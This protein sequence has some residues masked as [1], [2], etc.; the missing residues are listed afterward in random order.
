MV[1]DPK[2]SLLLRADGTY[3][4]YDNGT[5]GRYRYDAATG[6][7]T[8]LTGQLADM[9]PERTTYRRNER[10]AQIEITLDDPYSWSCGINLPTR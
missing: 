5:N 7:I 4:L 6:R 1:R 3:R 9:K 10:T 8:W 2:G